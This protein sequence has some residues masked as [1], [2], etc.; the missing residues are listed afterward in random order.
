MRA[1]FDEIDTR[2]DE[3]D[4]K[5]NDITE[6]FG[7]VYEISLAPWMSTL[8]Q[9]ED[10]KLNENIPFRRELHSKEKERAKFEKLKKLENSEWY[11]LCNL[12]PKT[13]QS[14]LQLS[15]PT[16]EFNLVQVDPPSIFVVETTLSNIKPTPHIFEGFLTNPPK[17][18][19]T[20]IP[21]LKLLQKLLQLER[22]ACFMND[23]SVDLYVA[24]CSPSYGKMEKKERKQY[25]KNHLRI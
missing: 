15:T 4:A 12:L 25:L 22:Q 8:F 7:Q 13:K 23:A 1:R 21:L 3:I 14:Q 11:L 2:F 9:E 5:F 6:S 17:Y 20:N 10:V 16:L 24:L 19:K 18:T